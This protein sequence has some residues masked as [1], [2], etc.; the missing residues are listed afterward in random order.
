MRRWARP[1][2]SGERSGGKDNLL[3]GETTPGEPSFRGFADAV[4]LPEACGGSRV[5]RPGNSSK[6]PSRIPAYMAVIV[7]SRVGKNGSALSG[8]VVQKV[9][10][11]TDSRYG[12]NPGHAGTGEIVAVRCH[13]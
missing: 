10:V 9:I 5:S 8:D 12:P 3:S 2:R 7:S 6:P 13:S 1:S 4:N 11:K